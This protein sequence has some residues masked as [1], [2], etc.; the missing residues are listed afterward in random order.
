M[1]SSVVPGLVRNAIVEHRKPRAKRQRN[2]KI[3]KSLAF[4]KLG[5]L[6]RD[7]HAEKSCGVKETNVTRKLLTEKLL[8]VVVKKRE[9]GFV[10]KKISA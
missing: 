3:K 7:C 9:G 2:R 4:G 8:F 5:E 10:F 6:A 1:I